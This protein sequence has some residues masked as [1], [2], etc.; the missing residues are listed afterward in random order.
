MCLI[1]FNLESLSYEC[2]ELSIFSNSDENE[3]GVERHIQSRGKVKS[4]KQ[5]LMTAVHETVKAFIS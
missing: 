5:Y 4:M 1:S 2:K 3:R